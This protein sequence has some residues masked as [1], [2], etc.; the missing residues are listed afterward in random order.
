MGRRAGKESHYTRGD[1]CA[2]MRRGE[3]N[4][5]KPYKIKNSRVVEG[6]IQKLKN[7]SLGGNREKRS[8]GRLSYRDMVKGLDVVRPKLIPPKEPRPPRSPKA[9]FTKVGGKAEGKIRLPFM[10]PKQKAKSGLQGKEAMV[11]WRGKT[12]M[13]KAQL[14]LKKAREK[15][16]ET[17]PVKFKPWEK[18][19]LLM[20]QAQNGTF[21]KGGKVICVPK[22]KQVNLSKAMELVKKAK[23]ASKM[24]Q[25]VFG[26]DTPG[27][28]SVKCSSKLADMDMKGVDLHFLH[29]KVTPPSKKA[30]LSKKK[31]KLIEEKTPKPPKPSLGFVMPVMSSRSSRVI[32]PTKRF[33]EQEFASSLFSPPS[34]AQ[35]S[36]WSDVP[37]DLDGSFLTPQAFPTP[38]ITTIKVKKPPKARKSD[39]NELFIKD[40]EKKKK[41]K[42]KK[43][44]SQIKEKEEQA[45][46]FQDEFLKSMNISPKK[47]DHEM[48]TENES[49]A[50]SKSRQRKEANRMLSMIS[51]KVKNGITLTGSQEKVLLSTPEPK[52]QH[53][54]AVYKK[55]VK[56]EALDEGETRALRISPL[57]LFQSM[58]T[59]EELMH[60]RGRID[61]LPSVNE[62][63]EK[64]KSGMEVTEKENEKLHCYKRISSERQSIQRSKQR[65]EKRLQSESEVQ[66]V[67]EDGPVDVNPATPCSTSPRGDASPRVSAA[68]S[69]P[70]TK[71]KPEVK[72]EA[73]QEVKQ[74]LT[75]E[76]KAKQ[77]ELKCE[78][79][80]KK[81]LYEKEEYIKNIQ[82]RAK[83]PIEKG[84][85]SFRALKRRLKQGLELSDAD[86]ERMKLNNK[87]VNS[88]WRIAKYKRMLQKAYQDAGKE[89]DLAVLEVKEPVGVELGG[90]SLGLSPNSRRLLT[91][92]SALYDSQQDALKK[93]KK[94]KKSKTSVELQVGGVPLTREERL[95]LKKKKKKKKLK[96]GAREEDKAGI[97]MGDSGKKDQT[98]R[99]KN[100]SS[101]LLLKAKQRK[102]KGKGVKL[103]KSAARK[104]KL[105]D[106]S[107]DEKESPSKLKSILHDK[108]I[109]PADKTLQDTVSRQMADALEADMSPDQTEASNVNKH[110]VANEVIV[111]SVAKSGGPRIKHVCRRASVALG[112]SP[113]RL[114][115]PVPASQDS[116]KLSA[117]PIKERKKLFTSDDENSETESGSEGEYP[118]NEASPR[119]SARK[120]KPTAKKR[121]MD[122]FINVDEEPTFMDMDD[123]TAKREPGKVSRPKKVPKQIPEMGFMPMP[124]V[125]EANVKRR[126]RCGVCSACLRK[127]DCEKC[128]N[129][130]DKPKYGG[131]GTKKQACIHRKCHNLVKM[132]MMRMKQM[133]ALRRMTNA[134]PPM[135]V[136]RPQKA[137]AVPK[138]RP[139]GA[140]IKRAGGDL[141]TGLALVPKNK[142]GQTGDKD[143]KS[144]A[145]SKPLRTVKFSKKIPGKH[146]IKTDFKDDYDM[147]VAWKRGMVIISSD[148]MIP[149]TICYLCGS[150]GKHDLVYCNVCC[151]PFHEFCLED[152]E[153]PLSG[154]KENWCCRNCRF[155]HVCD[156]QDQLLTCH[157]CHCSYHA[158]CLGPNYPTKPSKKRKIWVCSRCV[159]CKSC[160]ATT[161]GSDP[162]AQWMHGFSHCQECG[163]LFEKGN[164]CPVCK[165]CYEDDDFESKMMQCADCSRWVHAKCENLSDDQYRILTELPDSV[166]YRC[167]PC[168]KHKPTPWKVE[169]NEELQAGFVNVLNALYNCKSAG[170]LIWP[171]RRFKYMRKIHQG[172]S[173]LSST[174]Q[175]SRD[176]A[177]SPAPS[178]ASSL[179][180]ETPTPDRGLE[181]SG[182]GGTSS[183]QDDVE[184]TYSFRRGRT[185]RRVL[186][187]RRQQR[188]A[189]I[190]EGAGRGD[191]EGP[192]DSKDS[193]RVG[194]DAA[195]VDRTLKDEDGLKSESAEVDLVM[196][197]GS[198]ARSVE[199]IHPV[200]DRDADRTDDGVEK[201]LPTVHV[202][203]ADKCESNVSED[204]KIIEEDDALRTKKREQMPGD[205]LLS[206]STTAKGDVVSS[207]ESTSKHKSQE[208]ASPEGIVPKDDD[209][210]ERTTQPMSSSSEDIPM[211]SDD[212]LKSPAVVSTS[213]AVEDDQNLEVQTVSETKDRTD[214]VVSGPQCVD[215]SSVA[216]SHGTAHQDGSGGTLGES[217]MDTSNPAS[218][219]ETSAAE[220]VDID[221]ENTDVKEEKMD[222]DD[223]DGG[224]QQS[225]AEERT[226]EDS[227]TAIT[228]DATGSLEDTA[229]V[230]SDGAL[231]PKLEKEDADATCTL[232]FERKDDVVSP[233]AV[234]DIDP[235]IPDAVMEVTTSTQSEQEVCKT[236]AKVLTIAIGKKEEEEEKKDEEIKPTSFQFVKAKMMAGYYKSVEKFCKDCVT[237]FQASFNQET[238]LIPG[239]S[240]SNVIAKGAFLKIMTQMFPW[241]SVD[242]TR[243]WNGE[244]GYKE[245]GVHQ[246]AVEPPHKDHEYAQWRYRAL[247]PSITAQPSPFKKLPTPRRRHSI[248][249]GD[250]CSEDDSHILGIEDVSDPRRCCLCGV[251]GD[252]DPNNAGRL[253]YC[254]QDEWIH[255]NCALWS[256]EV[257]EE[258]DGSLI[259]VHAAISRGRMM[260]CEV[261]NN[262]GA[263]VGCCSRGCP[264]NFHFMCARSRNA[265]FQE[266]KKVYCFQHADKIDKAIMGSDLFGVLRRVCVSLDNMK[267]NRTFSQG[268]ETKNINVMIGSWSLES[269]GHLGFLSDTETNLF[270]LDFACSRVYWSTMDPCRRC[271]YTMRIIEVNPL[272]SPTTPQEINHTTEHSPGSYPFSRKSTLQDED[273]TDLLTDALMEATKES[274]E[275]AMAL[276]QVAALLAGSQTVSE[277][278]NAADALAATSSLFEMDDGILDSLNLDANL[279]SGL[280]SDGI[281]DMMADL[282]NLDG[283]NSDGDLGELSEAGEKLLPKDK[284]DLLPPGDSA[285]LD[286]VDLVSDAA[287]DLQ[288]E[289]ST[290][291]VEAPQTTESDMQS[292]PEDM[293]TPEV[294]MDMVEKP[295]EVGVEGS[296]DHNLENTETSADVR[297]NDD[298]EKSSDPSI[299]VTVDERAEVKRPDSP[300]ISTKK[301][302]F[303]KLVDIKDKQLSSVVTSDSP[304]V[305][306]IS[307]TSHTSVPLDDPSEVT[308]PESPLISPKKVPVLKLV[309]LP[310]EEHEKNYTESEDG[311]SETS[312]ISRS[313]TPCSNS[314]NSFDNPQTSG[315]L[316]ESVPQAPDQP[317]SDPGTSEILALPS[318][319]ISPSGEDSSSRDQPWDES[320][321]VMDL[322]EKCDNS[323]LSR[324][325]NVPGLANWD[326]EQI[327]VTK[328]LADESNDVGTTVQDD[329]P[330]DQ[331]DHFSCTTQEK[332]EACST[333][334]VAPEASCEEP[335]R[336]ATSEMTVSAHP[337]TRQSTSVNEQTITETDVQE[338]VCQMK[339]ALKLTEG[340]CDVP[341]NPEFCVQQQHM[342][343]EITPQGN[344]TDDEA[345]TNIPSL[346][347]NKE[348]PEEVKTSEDDNNIPDHSTII[349]I[350]KPE[351]PRDTDK[352]C[353]DGAQDQADGHGSKMYLPSVQT[354]VDGSEET[355][356][357]EIPLGDANQSSL[358]ISSKDQTLEAGLVDY[359]GEKS[360]T[361]KSIL[362]EQTSLPVQQQNNEGDIVSFGDKIAIGAVN[363]EQSMPKLDDIVCQPVDE[364]EPSQSPVR[365]ESD[366]TRDE[367]TKVANV[368]QEQEHSIDVR[369]EDDFPPLSS[370]AENCGSSGK[371]EKLVK[372]SGEEQMHHIEMNIVDDSSVALCEGIAAATEPNAEDMATP[373]SV[374]LDTDAMVVDQDSCRSTVSKQ[375]DIR[376]ESTEE[377]AIL[378]DLQTKSPIPAQ[379][380]AEHDSDLIVGTSTGG[381]LTEPADT[382]PL[383][384]T[385][386]QDPLPLSPVS[387]QSPGADDNGVMAVTSTSSTL[388]EQAD[389]HMQCHG[390]SSS[391]SPVPTQSPAELETDVM[392]A[393]SISSTCS[394][395]DDILNHYPEESTVED[396]PSQSPKPAQSLTELET[397]VIVDAPTNSALT[398]QTDAF[399][400]HLG[401]ETFVQDSQTQSPAAVDTDATSVT[402]TSSTISNNAYTVIDRPGESATVSDTP[403]QPSTKLSAGVSISSNSTSSADVLDQSNGIEGQDSYPACSPAT[404]LP[405]QDENT[406]KESLPDS[407][408][409]VLTGFLDDDSL[410][411]P[412]DVCHEVQDVSSDEEV[413]PIQRL[414]EPDPRLGD[415]TSTQSPSHTLQE[416]T[417]R[418]E[419]DT[420]TDVYHELPKDTRQDHLQEETVSD[421]TNV[422]SK[423]ADLREP[424]RKLDSGCIPEQSPTSLVNEDN[425]CLPMASAEQ[426]EKV[427]G[428]GQTHISTGH[429]MVIPFDGDSG[430]S[431]SNPVKHEERM[432]EDL[433]QHKTKQKETGDSSE[434]SAAARF[435]QS[436]NEGI[437]IEDEGHYENQ[438]LSLN[439]SIEGKAEV[440]EVGLNSKNLTEELIMQGVGEEDIM[441]IVA[442]QRSLSQNV[443]D[444]TKPVVAVIRTPPRRLSS[445]PEHES[446]FKAL[447][448]SL[449][450]SLGKKNNNNRKSPRTQEREPILSAF[451]SDL[452]YR[453]HKD[454]K[455]SDPVKN[456]SN[457]TENIVSPTTSRHLFKKFDSPKFANA[458][459][460]FMETKQKSLGKVVDDMLDKDLIPE[461]K[462]DETK[463][464]RS[465]RLAGLDLSSER[466]HHVLPNGDDSHLAG[467]LKN[468]DQMKRRTRHSSSDVV[469]SDDS[470]SKL[471]VLDV[472]HRGRKKY[473]MRTTSSR[474]LRIAD[475][476]DTDNQVFSQ[477]G[478]TI[479]DQEFLEG[480]DEKTVIRK[481]G[482]GNDGKRRLSSDEILKSPRSN[483]RKKSYLVSQQDEFVGDQEEKENEAV[484]GRRERPKKSIDS[485][486]S[487]EKECG[488]LNHIEAEEV[489]GR[490]MRTRG[491]SRK[492]SSRIKE[493]IAAELEDDDD[494]QE[495]EIVQKRGRGRPRKYPTP[496]V[497]NKNEVQNNKGRG[498]PRKS[499]YNDKEQG[500]SIE[501][502]EARKRCRDSSC[503]DREVSEEGEP[504]DEAM[505]KRK[506]TMLSDQPTEKDEILDPNECGDDDSKK[507]TRSELTSTSDE[508][509]QE[510]E[511]QF[512]RLRT[513]SSAKRLKPGEQPIEGER[514]M[515][516]NSDL[517][518]QE[519][520]INSNK[521]SVVTLGTPGDGMEGMHIGA[522]KQDIAMPDEAAVIQGKVA[523]TAEPE[524]SK[525]VDFSSESQKK[526][527]HSKKKVRIS[528]KIDPV[529]GAI[530]DV[531]TCSDVESTE[532]D[533]SI[534]DDPPPPPKVLSIEAKSPQPKLPVQT[535]W[536]IFSKS[537]QGASDLPNNNQKIFHVQTKS[538]TGTKKM[539]IGKDVTTNEVIYGNF[540]RSVRNPA[541]GPRFRGPNLNRIPGVQHNNTRQARTR[542]PFSRS[543]PV[544]WEG[545]T[546]KSSADAKLVNGPGVSQQA[547]ASLQSSFPQKIQ[548]S[549]ANVAG[550]PMSMTGQPMSNNL[551][552]AASSVLSSH[553]MPTSQGFQ[554]GPR[555]TVVATTTVSTSGSADVL[556]VI[557]STAASSTLTSS[558]QEQYLSILQRSYQGAQMQQASVLSGMM[559]QSYPQT[560]LLQNLGMP[561][562]GAVSPEVTPFI[563][564]THPAIMASP[565]LQTLQTIIQQAGV[566]SSMGQMTPSAS[567]LTPSPPRIIPVSPLVPTS[568]LDNSISGLITSLS[569][570]FPQQP[571]VVQLDSYSESSPF[572]IEHLYA[573]Q[574]P[575][576][577]SKRRKT[578][579]Q[580]KVWFDSY[581]NL[582]NEDDENE[583]T[584]NNVHSPSPVKS[585]LAKSPPV[586]L[587]LVKPP[588]VKSPIRMKNPTNSSRAR[589]K[590]PTFG[591]DEPRSSKSAIKMSKKKSKGSDASSSWNST[592]NLDP[593]AGLSGEDA[594]L[595]AMP[596]LGQPDYHDDS[597]SLLLTLME[598]EKRRGPS[599]TPRRPSN[600][601]HL[602][603]EIRSDDGF[604]TRAETMEEAWGRVVER[605]GE[606]RTNTRRKHLSFD[607]VKGMKVLGI[608]HEAIIYLLEQ[609]YGAGNCHNYKFK[610]HKH[611]ETPEDDEPP[612]NPHGCARAEVFKRTST[613][614]IFNFLASHHRNRPIFSEV[615]QQDESSDIQHKSSRRATSL[616]DLPMAMRFRHLKQTAKEAVGVYRSG[617]HGRGLYC[618]R[619]IEA[620]EMVIE[621][622]GTVIRSI[623]TD[624]REKYYESK[625]IG[626]YMFR[627]DDFDVVDATTHGNAARFI[628]HSCDPNCFSRVIEIGGQKHII[629]FAS[630]RIARGEELTYDYKFPIEEV[631]IPCNC[632][633]RKCRK[634]LN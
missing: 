572:H 104:L 173:R 501:Q 338:S 25:Q 376:T 290:P 68:S 486:W 449:S 263:T 442:S 155:C 273:D 189:G 46:S 461:E 559:Q 330:I 443:P 367:E 607:G 388:N 232:D 131:P 357:A 553:G 467:S 188:H 184:E 396:M 473:P 2:E 293:H 309:K 405:V 520:E 485:M 60:V 539:I 74:E 377:I 227:I 435:V 241:F 11:P 177:A 14:L 570:P 105:G 112:Y 425:T 555:T 456:E 513:R 514:E 628:N 5:A 433:T 152:D 81:F 255:I 132:K 385:F 421:V 269:L 30:K 452:N 289:T 564:Q 464:R 53:L 567:S 180:R 527:Q 300:L 578:P 217:R 558:A 383:S 244:E 494:E 123:F 445:D 190:V 296:I 97:G 593:F 362:I 83:T 149:R 573:R 391:V 541:V 458:F 565:T 411:I 24:N 393:T 84:M 141:P 103:K 294:N 229:E 490:P 94:K 259:N 610:F 603:F 557:T 620:G 146:F 260:R 395:L 79:L 38:E 125:E 369:R 165:K 35:D 423:V 313:T 498:R 230:A 604:E 41:K 48:K 37:S 363:E 254:G 178:E 351:E 55:V 403:T 302:P 119:L 271:I 199:Q 161:P 460:S 417:T 504:G 54:K 633:A 268:L 157:K 93:R 453:C 226:C 176:S 462:T 523:L 574:K 148:P 214:V 529:T 623:L 341:E 413:E 222:V 568:P 150:N 310:L 116:L 249:G 440:P 346:S 496:V 597:P 324:E 101:K 400:P 224:D 612:V 128:S 183:A 337:E 200:F 62:I 336:E 65:A 61:G 399:T 614:D 608:T 82:E 602:M 154:E 542:G 151:E 588:S 328:D 166:P 32:K 600:R 526:N 378:E 353:V 63:L 295:E 315:V 42:E 325:E 91:M 66:L 537:T 439:H 207:V 282:G 605:V 590:N 115:G 317:R 26:S 469:E 16:S 379:S 511:E 209:N 424:L 216:D 430:V 90:D 546:L 619:P 133:K 297:E 56:K 401:E 21:N 43:K 493:I 301:M 538:N 212:A 210:S 560:G 477:E 476:G 192:G 594:F 291:L 488:T 311:T 139:A 408:D 10:M 595:A 507:R 416:D 419:V 618:R 601:P 138:I 483:Q 323:K 29:R 9:T 540:P 599:T 481:Y 631:K 237:I 579:H 475:S 92:G 534:S 160:G 561:H 307:E 182:D 404:H 326:S 77:L 238:D 22:S 465:S 519:R 47:I 487:P 245:N 350:A 480:Q 591:V 500:F 231:S 508:E 532:D 221:V 333:S 281:M 364:V 551:P 158:E 33:I 503:G 444:G 277:I 219:G 86:N 308:R 164:Y 533:E 422:D 156:H 470:S 426:N 175:E 549:V 584:P 420:P 247:M 479:P 446:I 497:Q 616:Q 432:L 414:E 613:F 505:P 448:S 75:K 342:D 552:N 617:I 205:G 89:E 556:S 266:D 220:E 292:A 634:Y 110:Q 451:A 262:L 211:I 72:Q 398:E 102:Q 242:E 409:N 122:G 95:K 106:A 373:S 51:A 298:I 575:G 371:D 17:S 256:A 284:P 6:R 275:A 50:E 509:Q 412:E 434:T 174:G 64:V 583:D 427:A 228:G 303:V 120:R 261:C 512:P 15:K 550:Q 484:K 85:P 235:D 49:E 1:S 236:P 137:P 272:T 39:E 135:P 454:A 563:N 136:E 270:P 169:V 320:P 278:Q 492:S 240:K 482:D 304:E 203:D 466:F 429:I 318:L 181:A 130:L 223:A 198:E 474:L 544:V 140:R 286:M 502:N 267:L 215:D 522:S 392:G 40:I 415:L 381:T 402:P 447:A 265:M 114:E 126:S 354:E 117:L 206:L 335:V 372:M 145:S 436:E 535:P 234:P 626:C 305:S 191:T 197:A 163:K 329:G 257:F 548:G 44:K 312:E 566:Q 368:S 581:G 121:A 3:W 543:S 455:E 73:K 571:A 598:Q 615:E 380:H 23:G 515:D 406:P 264:A 562:R 204:G 69:S 334:S 394:K 471:D 113:A 252:D 389:I 349:T 276:D 76:E 70:R 622:S 274:S 111:G 248:I 322:Q 179:E 355:N 345:A 361:E 283:L 366:C 344:L 569:Q 225:S 459:K 18:K 100:A 99:K 45:H 251:M 246:V 609:L 118:S 280:D 339:E 606:L 382:L 201:V 592:T 463:K 359:S 554:H 587:Y 4:T 397:E 124:V 624:K 386:V 428:D 195:D 478:N 213:A 258:V 596:N 629:I 87:I 67:N 375:G 510:S 630:R 27:K 185:V 57:V 306:D 172:D 187:R 34:S 516:S 253:L 632:G 287:K 193:E 171:N 218:D 143:E 495:T 196:E 59:G 186:R 621:Y 545:Y 8:V 98:L 525:E 80:M 194:E 285:S 517:I 109:S 129:C 627:I 52:W 36:D 162:K 547:S 356:E 7:G 358:Q 468:P 153:R 147:T 472:G 314:R 450:N 407:S 384:G 321:E 250:G 580:V 360:P 332:M 142:K 582:K 12:K 88:R 418:P 144:D 347:I 343:I 170:H 531:M 107:K 390:E 585:P 331:I 431:A 127:T 611:E 58:R 243:I 348:T 327:P 167:P 589:V 457:K 233:A 577:A 108:L 586:K 518:T 168:A 387:T 491:L 208:N 239:L 319:S 352:D 524:Q 340:K 13:E 576:G 521:E 374:E 506:R 528:V 20:A 159:K 441:G 299:S 202:L 288:G 19:K 530:S 31:L 71:K 78:R 365:G 28:R 134:P 625:G 316:S 279:N 536:D 370:G 437:N 499:E 96:G 438:E 489:E 410:S